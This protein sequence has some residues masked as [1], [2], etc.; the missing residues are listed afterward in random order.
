MHHTLNTGLTPQHFSQVICIVA[1]KLAFFIFWFVLYIIYSFIQL[2]ILA[3][4]KN[5][6]KKNPQIDKQFFKQT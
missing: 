4:K 5:V 6:G 2:G 1:I 3:P